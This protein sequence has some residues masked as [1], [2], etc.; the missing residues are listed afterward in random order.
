MATKVLRKFNESS[1]GPFGL[2]CLSKILV[3]GF[4]PFSGAPDDVESSGRYMQWPIQARGGHERKLTALELAIISESKIL[5]SSKACQ[6]VVNA[7]YEGEVVYTSLSFVDILPDHYKYHPVS[8]YEPRKAPLLNHYRLVVPRLR[9]MI[10]IVQFLVLVALYVLAMMHRNS[11]SLYIYEGL[12][13]VYTA[14]W[15][16]EEFAAVIEH[17]WAVHSQNL[18]SFLDITFMLIYGVYLVALVHD[19]WMGYDH[20]HEGIALHI[21]CV[22]A[23]ILLTR[24]A[25][26]L[27]PDNIVFISLHA[28]MKDFLILTF[29][30]VWCVGGFFLALQWLVTTGEGTGPKWYTVAK[31]LLWIWFG[32]DGTGIQESVQFH[33]VL[34]PA[35]IVAFAF[36]GNTLFLTI[37]VALLTNTFSRI[38]A[39]ETAEIQFRRAVLT[40]EGVK[41]D[42]IFAYPPPFNIAALAILLPLKFLVSPRQFH[43]IHVAMTRFVNAPLLL[44]ITFYERRWTGNGSSTS[45]GS[46]SILRWRFTGFSP[47]GDIQ[48]VF[49]SA[50]PPGVLEEADELDGMSE[51]GFTDNDAI[52]RSSRDVKP[53]VTFRLSNAKQPE[54]DRSPSL[55]VTNNDG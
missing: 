48:A 6:R 38:V 50:P 16:L 45:W 29:L 36:L 44:L 22:A 33:V 13:V 8:L 5:I 10:E 4:D 9:N 41:S 14:G 1:P 42:A 39:A 43:T 53:P 26:N 49:E 2:L 24:A 19:S 18:W 23:P 7:V 32:L 37:L 54:R 46:K 52:S 40:F 51:M 30:A 28:M 27:M 12:F 31:W 20:V 21:L 55:D 17:G 25:F 34:G 47:H 3:E 15:V 11:P 35:L